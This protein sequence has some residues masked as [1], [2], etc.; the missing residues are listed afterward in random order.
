M[1]EVVQDSARILDVVCPHCHKRFRLAVGPQPVIP[2]KAPAAEPAPMPEEEAAFRERV[3]DGIMKKNFEIPLLPHVALKVIRLTGDTKT[4]MQDLAK[5]ILTDQGIATKILKI[6]NSPV[7][8]A[9]VEITT[10]SQALVRLGQVEVKNLM[11]AISMQSKVFKSGSFQE[12]AKELWE[13]SI[14][15]AFAARVVANALRIEKEEAFLGGLMHDLGK[16]VLLNLLE[17]SLKSSSRPFK[18]SKEL[19][20]SLLNQFHCDV[21]EMVAKNW[22]L[23]HHVAETIHAIPRSREM[24]TIPREI[25]AVILGNEMCEAKGIGLDKTETDISAGFGARA[26]SLTPDA[27]AELERRFD[28]IFEQAKGA[29]L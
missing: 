14:G 28:Q 22:E 11:L 25:A 15:V 20:V 27:C 1:A 18:P 2:S 12:T 3:I 5:V 13:H 26:L 19:I 10:I 21:G 24:E 7:Y 9:A 6:A 16:M 29:F 8:A 17:K 4:S 23:P